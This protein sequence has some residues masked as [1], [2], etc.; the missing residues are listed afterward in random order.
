MLW[1][2]AANNAAYSSKHARSA[3]KVIYSTAVQNK[4]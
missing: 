2:S 1:L 4:E 3:A